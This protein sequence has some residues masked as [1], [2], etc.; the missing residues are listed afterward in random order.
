MRQALV[1]K[2]P[3]WRRGPEISRRVS[4][5]PAFLR[6]KSR[7]PSPSL[8]E[9]PNTF[10][11]SVGRSNPAVEKPVPV[12]MELGLRLS[13]LSDGSCGLNCLRFDGGTRPAIEGGF[14]RVNPLPQ[15]LELCLGQPEPIATG[16]LSAR[17]AVRIESWRR[18]G[19]NDQWP[20]TNDQRIPRSKL[21]TGTS[22][23]VFYLA[24]RALA[25]FGHL[26]LVIGIWRTPHMTHRLHE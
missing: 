18:S 8:V 4:A 6:N 24:I 9:T 13:L 23:A 10:V 21:P 3:G 12:A 11:P 7:A 15:V 17:R 26:T 2:K 25:F 14:D 1:S 16:S 19:M 20:I 5:V 22:R